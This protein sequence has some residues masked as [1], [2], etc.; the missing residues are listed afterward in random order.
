MWKL[1][2]VEGRRGRCWELK[3]ETKEE[4]KNPRREVSKHRQK[5]TSWVTHWNGKGRQARERG[6]TTHTEKARLWGR[7]MQERDSMGRG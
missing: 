3:G 5:V 2:D 4:K 6:L 1:P 7:V